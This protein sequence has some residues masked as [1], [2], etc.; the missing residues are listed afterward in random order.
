MSLQ[1]EAHAF[2]DSAISC[3]THP[4]PKSGKVVHDAVW[5]SIHLTTAEVALLDTPLLQR[6]RYL[7]QTGF[8]FLVFPSARHSRFEHS[9][10]VL[11]QTDKHIRALQTRFA[12][13]VRSE[14]L[15]V[16]KLAALL[17]DCSHGLF[18]HT[19]EEIY[20]FLPDMLAFTAKGGDYEEHKASELI[21]RFLLQSPRFADAMDFLTHHGAPRVSGKDL[22]P[23]ICGDYDAVLPEYRWQVE[24]INGPLDADKLDYIARDSLH[25][26]LRMSIDLDRFWLSTEIQQLP[27]GCLDGIDFAQT[28]LVIN[29]SGLA[30]VEGIVFARF[31]LTNAVYQHP[32]I[33]ASDCLFKTWIESQQTAGRFL[34]SMDFVQATDV[35]YIAGRAVPHRSELLKRVLVLSCR[36]VNAG[37]TDELPPSL[38][39]L[40]A[41]AAT[42]SGAKQL[43]SLA[44]QIAIQAGIPDQECD[45]LWI[46]L[47]AF[48]K[49]QDL[50]M[51]IVNLGTTDRPKFA[52][53]KDVFPIE[54][55]ARMFRDRNWR[56]HVFAP[57]QY[58]DSKRL[59]EAA[60]EVLEAQLPGV[61]IQPEAF[62]WCKLEP[63]WRR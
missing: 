48:P 6:L 13:H 53:M 46:D 19:S 39:A 20:R 36:T 12:K 62:E 1:D 29:G 60:K 55:W 18:S 27:K 24:I 21:A 54:P 59:K 47:P 33:R 49:V 11:H 50:G 15:P 4:F 61:A 10:G 26:G 51:M 44:R 14:T 31:Q 30:A 58:T 56:G 43:R 3:S 28:R 22:V 17:H 32:K 2:A 5:G 38:L 25:T 42:E 57:A 37:A 8:A 41:G 52:Y 63:P 35:D 16:L 34:R 9:L 40:V 45:L 23:L 7:H